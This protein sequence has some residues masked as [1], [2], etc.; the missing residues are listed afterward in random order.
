MKQSKRHFKRV[1]HHHRLHENETFPNRQE[2]RGGQTSIHTTKKARIKRKY[3]STF[4]A[5]NVNGLLSKINSSD[6]WKEKHALLSYLRSANADVISITE[7]WIPGNGSSSS[8][9]KYTQPYS[10]DGTNK[11]YRESANG[12][13]SLLN[14]N[15]FLRK[16]ARYYNCFPSKIRGRVDAGE[17][18]GG[19]ETEQ[20]AFT[21]YERR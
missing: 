17:R 18:G 14:L 4:L 21:F 12:I 6:K 8:S 11:S 1:H 7:T 16:Y 19:G 9:K 15:G 13:E 20:S 2:R 3:P 5:V 10:N